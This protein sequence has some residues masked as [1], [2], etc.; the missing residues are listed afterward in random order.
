MTVQR[1]NTTNY[2]HPQETNLLNLHKSMDYNTQGQPVIRTTSGASAAANDS[3]GRL[4]VS[5]P[6]TLYDS[7]HRYDDNGKDSIKTVGSGASSHDAD[8][9]SILMTVGTAQ[10]DEVVREST[11]VFA[12]QPGKSL[13]V[14]MSFTMNP[15][16]SGLRQRLGFFDDENGVYLQLEGNELSIILRSSSDGSLGETKVVQSNW[17]VDPLTGLGI[18]PL[19][20]DITKSHI[21]WIDLEWLGVGSVRCGFV[22]NGEFVHCHS[23]HHAN[24]MDST[25][26]GT[27]CLPICYEIK[28]LTTT[29][30]AS[31][32]RQICA[33]VLSEGGYELHGQP[34]AIGHDLQAGAGGSGII[35]PYTLLETHTLYPVASIRLKSTRVGSIVVP[36]SFS[37]AVL[38]AANFK[39]SIVGRAATSGG[40]WY[41]AGSNSAVEYKLDATSLSSGTV[42]ETGYIAAS[43]QSS[44]SPQL[45]KSTFTYQLERNRFTNTFYE[46]VIMMSTSASNDPN[47]LASINWQE[48]T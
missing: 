20:L 2:A 38:S 30:G 10:N 33:T 12:Y 13:L 43:N 32:L 26:M 48:Y 8:S 46:F 1:T 3:F 29:N 14:L 36:T 5:N 40:T 37:I 35:G 15:A 45:A 25:Y 34:G 22:I 42:F 39:F 24:V 17:N 21:F 23:F 27:A 7:F 9:S 18:S 28:N 11:K 41:S 6:F 4:R 47:V 16:R 31:S 44:T 19:T